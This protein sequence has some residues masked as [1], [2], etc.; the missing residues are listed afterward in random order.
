MG[1]V[2]QSQGALLLNP[3]GRGF[4]IMDRPGRHVAET[5][6]MMFVVVPREKECA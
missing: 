2:G 5:A 1:G 3:Q 6:A 4:A